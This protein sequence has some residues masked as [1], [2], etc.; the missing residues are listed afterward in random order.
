L[1]FCTASIDS[2]LIVSME[3]CSISEF[4]NAP[5]RGGLLREVNG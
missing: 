3:S 2:V 1:A 5:P 4:G